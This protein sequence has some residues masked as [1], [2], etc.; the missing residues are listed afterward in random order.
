MTREVDFIRPWAWRIMLR[1]PQ[2]FSDGPWDPVKTRDGFGFECGP[3]WFS[4]VEKTL[5]K[6]ARIAREDG[7]NRLRVR[8]VKEK[9]GGLRIYL[10]CSNDRVDAVVAAAQLQSLKTC[11]LCGG[12]VQT[13]PPQ[14]GWI[15]TR[16][17]ACIVGKAR[18]ADI[19]QSTSLAYGP[20]EQTYRVL[21]LSDLHLDF[22]LEANEEPL[23][24][25]DSQVFRSIDLVILAGDLT[26][27]GHVR[28]QMAL[29]WL[30]ERVSPDKIWAFPGNH[31][32]YGGVI[33]QDK[34]LRSIIESF[35]GH[36]AQKAE[37]RLGGRRFLCATLWTNMRLG[38]AVNDNMTAAAKVM[39]DYRYTRVASRE[40][41]R[42][43]PVDTIAL[44]RDQL[45]WLE[46]ALAAPFDGETVV[47][48]HHAPYADCLTAGHSLPAA[49][50]SDLSQ[51]IQRHQPLIW[52]H[53]HVHKRKDFHV[54][55][56]RILNVALG[57]PEALDADQPKNDPLA[58]LIS[59][60]GPKATN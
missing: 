46:T 23:P 32:A 6:L 44:H 22:W 28:W 52:A 24:G 55:R 5:I 11:D 40:Y 13:P 50:A 30:A 25:L 27:K 53:G 15:V 18:A 38:G 33:E 39:N 29:E 21:I 17:P 43:H 4:L 41:A 60:V 3:G 45:N 42:L 10:S 59:W 36:Y 54:G 8:Q 9:F 49:Y 34:K 12:A 48:S 56:T 2:L 16:C 57:Y 20:E 51:L 47:V 31:D 7:L 37:I 1:T 58:G 26:N 35:G 19:L 14:T